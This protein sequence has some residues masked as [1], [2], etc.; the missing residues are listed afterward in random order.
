MPVGAD[1]AGDAEVLHGAAS[2]DIAEE[3]LITVTAVVDIEASD[4][5][6]IAVKGAGVGGGFAGADWDPLVRFV[7]SGDRAVFANIHVWVEID[8][9]GE[10]GAGV[11]FAAVDF[12]AKFRELLCAADLVRI[13]L[14]AVARQL[15]PLTTL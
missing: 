5:V 8:I 6:A 7:A 9:V 2:A 13:L 4:G 14:R 10:D 11:G 12:V 1:I 15:S 3:A